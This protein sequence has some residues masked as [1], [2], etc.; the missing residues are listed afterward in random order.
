MDFLAGLNPQQRE[1]VA[2]VEGP[3]LLLAG[4]GSGKTRV[5][6][7][8]IAH[9]VEARHIPGPA[10]LAVTFT[11]KAADEMRQRV[12][13]LLAASTNPGAP[14]LSTFHSF[15]V[16]L[17]RRDG[18][19]L[20]DIRSGFT[21]RFTI[22]D[23]DDQLALMKSIYKQLG[24]DEKFMQYRAVLSRISHAKSH[25][26]TPLDWYKA[27]TDPALTRL[28]KIYDVY[29][30]RLL[31]ANA[32]D[33]D[34]LLLESVR[35]LRHDAA[36]RG[37][38]NRRFE[39]VMIDEYQD[40]NRSQYELMRLLT[41]TR[42]N[43][44]VVG[45]EDQSIYGWRGADIRNILDFERDYPDA[46]VIRLEENYRSTKN[47]LE[48]ASALVANNKERKGKWL[49]TNSGVGAKIGFY[50]APNGE[51]EA[52]FIADT[53][54][55]ILAKSP[56]ER[57]AVLYRT[58]FQ[59]RQIEEALRRY[60]RKY[61]V[62]GGF[63]FYQRAEVK[64]LLAYLK[65]LLSPHDSVSLLRIVNTPARGI[66][67]GTVEQM[68]TFALEHG[69]SLWN[70]LPRMVEDK[71]FPARAEAA[72]KSFLSLLG[73]LAEAA[74]SKP[75]DQLLREILL[76]TGYE[77]MLKSDSSPDSES[78]LGNLEELVNAAAEAAERGETAAE[79]LD[80]A[81]L[82]S[83]SDSLD[84]HAAV[85]LLTIHN[86]KGLEFANVF[87]AGL[88]EGIFPHS[89]SLNSEAAMEEERRLCYVG[90]TRAE[91]RL[92]LSWARYRR[93]FGGSQPEVSLPSRFLNE[94]PPSL[95]E[96]LSPTSEPRADDVDLYAE[97]HDVREAVKRN[98]Y[99]GRTYN[100]VE[101]IAQFFAERGM[102]PPSGFSRRPAAN[103]GAAAPQSAAPQAPSRPSPA[104]PAR[105]SNLAGPNRPPARSTQ[106][107]H[108]GF[109]SGSVVNHPKYGRGTVLRREGEG[110][111][112]KL[113][114]SF[115]GY[116]LKKIVEK[117]AGIRIDE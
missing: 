44:C 35:L 19:A 80:H 4:A 23:D 62:V 83:D 101:N 99:T 58:N 105:P 32:L 41:E 21:R 112:A 109:R 86:A 116:G 56:L 12:A 73:Q 33:F 90:M 69:L 46:V 68:E 106:P 65:V 64:D 2:H 10:I 31:Q 11:N 26:Q 91:K 115:P 36:L 6:T 108:A 25:N 15:C 84:Q 29:E 100:S 52:L 9:L 48:A 67:K 55:K 93:R 85:S 57:V 98:L 92:Y 34:D 117:Y 40:T 51:N 107:R 24:L 37:S 72:V 30:E 14:L 59:S 38:Y 66:G 95:R 3:L 81:A 114:I 71:L 88:E 22:Y 18:E 50:E 42:H 110:E 103:N 70:A 87:I 28:A 7:H 27:A 89:R 49:W 94:V 96:K 79:F 39:F 76:R 13:T 104:A 74:D 20:S 16:R 113:T 1:A 8:R 97:Q 5:I 47:I 53:I 17:L 78:R 43:V 111:D 54:E 60:G 102:P 63:S 45:D 61:L 75:V 77:A 82:V